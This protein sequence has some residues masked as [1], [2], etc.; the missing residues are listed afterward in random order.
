MVGTSLEEQGFTKE[1]IPKHVSVKESVFPFAK[2]QGVDPILGPEMKST[3]EVMG[4][5]D[6]FGE[7][8]A[9]A[10]LG[11]G[12]ILPEGGLALISVKESDK[13]GVSRVAYSLIEQGFSLVATRGTANVLRESG[14]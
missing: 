10:S 13:A 6:T 11:A 9:K 1:V 3:G 2:F 4:V 5:G 14:I 7:A 8:F 12:D